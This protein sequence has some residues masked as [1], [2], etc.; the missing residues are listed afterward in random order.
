M[1][2]V[3]DVEEDVVVFGALALDFGGDGGGATG[4]EKLSCPDDEGE[5]EDVP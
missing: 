1:E 3:L 2:V 5:P 4:W